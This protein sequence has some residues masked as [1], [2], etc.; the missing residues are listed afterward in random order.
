MI[1]SSHST[2]R[3]Y[4]TAR[5]PRPERLAY[6]ATHTGTARN[7]QAMADA[8]M[9]LLLGPD[10]LD[11]HGP[12]PLP[13][14]LDNGAWGAHRSGTTFD[15]PAFFF[16]PSAGAFFDADPLPSG[17]EPRSVVP[18]FLSRSGAVPPSSSRVGSF[19]FEPAAAASSGSVRPVLAR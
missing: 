14:A 15:A 3:R 17:L 4:A 10:Q 9:R 2:F 13:Y 11:R 18:D 12:M 6:Y 1:C 16:E 19:A 8:G 7:L 5:L